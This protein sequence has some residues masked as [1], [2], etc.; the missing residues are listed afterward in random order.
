MVFEFQ[1]GFFI[2]FEF[3]SKLLQGLMGTVFNEAVRRMVGAFEKRAGELYGDSI[4]GTP[5]PTPTVS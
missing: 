3:R 4:Q 2:D 1:I 5:A